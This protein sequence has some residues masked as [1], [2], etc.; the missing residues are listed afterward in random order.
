MEWI[1]AVERP[2]A[3]QR[4]NYV[5]TRCPTVGLSSKDEGCEQSEPARRLVHHVGVGDLLGPKA[6]R[7][8]YLPQ[9]PDARHEAEP[10]EI[11]ERGH[12]R[13][14][15]AHRQIGEA[16][17]A[18]EHATIFLGQVHQRAEHALSGPGDD[19]AMPAGFLRDPRAPRQ[20]AEFPHQA[21]A[22]VAVE[23]DQRGLVRAGNRSRILS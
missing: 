15:A 8:L 17:E 18:R 6:E 19:A 14:L 4:F 13:L 9:A 12:D 22:L 7:R 3:I 10:L 1:R 11:I 2:R 16:F 5:S 21:G 23:G 20:H